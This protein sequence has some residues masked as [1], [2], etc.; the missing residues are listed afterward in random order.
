MNKIKIVT[1]ST[2]YIKKEYAEQKGIEIVPLT[3]HFEGEAEREGYPGEFEEFFER[4][5]E[6]KSF[7]TT[8]QPSLG[9]FAEVF[10]ELVED[11]N[12]VMSLF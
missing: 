10:R 5:K 4:L 2:A 1:D 8:S 12:E 9:T 3:I 7:P 6:S 11:G